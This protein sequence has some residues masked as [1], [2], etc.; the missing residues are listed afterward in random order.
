[1]ASSLTR[2]VGCASR[3]VIRVQPREAANYLP[4]MCLLETVEVTRRFRSVVEVAIGL[5]AKTVVKP[6]SCSGTGNFDATSPLPKRL[7]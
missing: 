5:L 6:K 3:D 1:M 7:M 2:S 4:L